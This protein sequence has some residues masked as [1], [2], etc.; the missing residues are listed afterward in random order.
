MFKNYFKTAFRTLFK[1]KLYTTLNVAGL[2]FGLS[3]FLLIGLYVFDELTFDQQHRNADRIYRV[4]EHKNVNGEATTIAGIG[5]KLAEESKR[6]V[7][8]VEK[9]TRIQRTGRANILST[10]NPSNFFQETVTVADQHFLDIFDFPLISGDRKTALAEPNTILI[11]EDLAMRLF[12]KKDGLLGKTLQFSF[13]E[14]PLKITGILKN[15][16]RNSSFDFSSVM[17][18]A[19]YASTEFYKNIVEADWLSNNFSVFALLKPNADPKSVADGM[20]KLVHSNFNAPAGTT[21]SFSLQPLKDVHLKSGDIVEGARNSNVD[22]IPKGSV[23]Y[24]KIFSFIALFVL[25]IAGINYMNLTTA[26]ASSR[27]KEIGVRKAIGAIRG[28]LIKQFLVESLLVTLF[29]FL[30]ALW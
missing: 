4:V 29:A 23:I 30:V 15:H 2:A 1:N 25:L 27:L 11:N 24:I 21:Y 16:P 26:R 19:S 9:T 20:S 8:G 6:V 22:P 13:W 14:P 28:N 3:C 5:Y 18:D 10:D 17:S 12:G 7:P